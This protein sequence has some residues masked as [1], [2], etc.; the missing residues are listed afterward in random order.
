MGHGLS[1]FHPIFAL[2]ISLLAILAAAVLAR[3]L[4]APGQAPGRF[5]S[6]DGLR[7]LL[8]LGVFLHHA[9]MWYL[10]RQ[11]GKWDEPP[12]HLYNHLGESSV[13]LFFMITGFLFFSKLLAGR[14]KPIDWLHLYVSRV[15]RLFPLYLFSMLLLFAAVAAQT[16]F[17][18][19]EPWP[20]LLNEVLRWLS[21]GVAGNPDL[22]G[23][24]L[25]FVID[26]GVV[27]SLAYEWLFYAALPLIGLVIGVTPPRRVVLA[28]LLACAV[29]VMLMRGSDF[30]YLAVF[31]GGILAALC[32]QSPRFCA[33]AR[34]TA[35]SLLALAC[36]GLAVHLS[37]GAFNTTTTALLTVAF[38]LIAC[39]NTLFGVLTWQPIQL[40]GDMGYSIYLLH[41]FLLYIGLRAAPLPGLGAPAYAIGHW[42]AVTAMAVPLVVLCY[43][44]FRLIERPAMQATPRVV[45]ALLRRRKRLAAN[46]T[47]KASAPP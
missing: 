4:E 10:Y 36:L 42:R 23:M 30:S 1:A 41:G 28:S 6:L 20:R 26:A 12:S 19:N 40:I 21:F 32:A 39:G 43:A 45:G 13:A 29:I 2:G 38:T 31:G 9:S 14:H 27:W 18:L 34:G 5:A 33:L 24:K 7:G 17:R 25:T 44:T 46:S 22:N 8:V 35:A 16:G 3:F 11:S 47:A 15:L 37:P